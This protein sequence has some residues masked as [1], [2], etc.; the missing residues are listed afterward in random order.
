MLLIF[1]IFLS[2]RPIFH[3]FQF[4]R[5]QFLGGYG[6]RELIYLLQL[7]SL[8]LLFYIYSHPLVI[9]WWSSGKSRSEQEIKVIYP[10]TLQMLCA[11]FMSSSMADR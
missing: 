4:S 10:S 8:L 5:P 1:Q 6:S 11:V 7:L 3:I 2:S 9:R